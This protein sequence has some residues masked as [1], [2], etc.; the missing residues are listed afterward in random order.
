M[1]TG[2]VLAILRLVI[3]IVW[4]LAFPMRGF[5]LA[6]TGLDNAFLFYIVPQAGALFVTRYLA[7]TRFFPLIANASIAVTIIGTVCFPV[8][9]RHALPLL[10]L[11]GVSGAGLFVKVVGGLRRL[12]NPP[13]A[14][15]ACLAAGNLALLALMK[16]PWSPM[17]VH[18]LLASLLLI[19]LFSATPRCE[20]KEGNSFVWYLPFLFVYH[21]VSGLM[22]G[23]LMDLYGRDAFIDGIELLF[24]VGTAVAGAYFFRKKQN[25]LLVLGI[26]GGMLSFSLLQAGGALA[27]NL[28]MFAIQGSEGFVDLF[29]L[30]LVLSRSDCLLVTGPAFGTVC[31]GIAVGQVVSGAAGGAVG[32]IAGGANLFLTVAVFIF[33][34]LIR[35]KEQDRGS[36]AEP[37]DHANRPSLN[38]LLQS[39]QKRLSPRERAVLDCVTRGK[40]FKETAEELSLS[41][42][43]VKTYMKRI[44]EKMGVIGKEELLAMIATEGDTGGV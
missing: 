44:Y 29:V 38:I 20:A 11:L 2:S 30:V 6:K 27:V 37:P 31:A 26:I 36:R 1:Y 3:F 25:L 8:A 17:A 43:S 9:G 42:S 12:D 28:S 35:K 23:A 32:M 33:I 39:F 16:L 22:Y 5:L 41:E 19:P 14:A 21:L 15:A 10:A 4:L 18:L 40:T 34:F 24:Y 7:S 13:L